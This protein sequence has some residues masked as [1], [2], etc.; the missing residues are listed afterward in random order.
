MSDLSARLA[1]SLLYS[2]A[3]TMSGLP[4]PAAGARR[5]RHF[6]GAYDLFGY[7]STPQARLD[8]GFVAHT[9]GRTGFEL[10]CDPRLLQMHCCCRTCM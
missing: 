1:A 7:I 10:S 9:C 2:V 8:E 4:E 5:A 6:R 3:A